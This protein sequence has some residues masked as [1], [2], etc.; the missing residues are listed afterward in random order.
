MAAAHLTRAVFYEHFRDKQELFLEI[1][2]IHFQ[3]TMAVSARAF[4]SASTWP[5]RVWEGI[6]AIADL[7]TTNPELAHFGALESHV[8]GTES[9]RLYTTDAMM[10]FS[11]FLEE[12]YRQRPEGRRLAPLCSEAIACALFETIYSETRRKRLRQLPDLVP[13][14]VYFTLAPYLGPE[15]A[16]A[17]VE[18]KLRELAEVG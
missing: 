4:F 11:V 17:I 16:G 2:Q 18:G 15:Q 3:Q 5:E 8:V 14:V 7:F 10:A 12:G 9:V 13:A 6:R 1:Q